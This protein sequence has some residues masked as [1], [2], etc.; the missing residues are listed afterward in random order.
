MT[1][2]EVTPEY[3]ARVCA[4]LTDIER[5]TL[6]LVLKGY[7]TKEIA[8]LNCRATKTVDRESEKAA[9]ELASPAE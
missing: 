3:A 6:V 4:E 1:P 2:R 7:S 5:K 8:R 9:A